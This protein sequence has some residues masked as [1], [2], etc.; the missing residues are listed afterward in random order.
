MVMAFGGPDSLSAVGPFMERLMKGRKPGP[1][2][3]ERVKDKYQIIGGKSPL[4]GITKKQA[5][6]LEEE[7]NRTC[8]EHGQFAAY[9]GMRYWH[10]FIEEAIEQMATDGITRAFAISMSPHDS[11]VS[12]GAY[13]EE[14]ERV[15]A[16]KN[17]NISIEM[18][19]GMYNN[20][21]FVDAVVEKITEAL[22]RIPEDARDDVQ[23][24]FSAHSLP[25]AY[26]DGGDPYVD[27]IN[28]TIRE[29]L[30]KTGSPNW[31]IAYQSK[32]SI[33]GEWLGPMMEDVLAEIAAE[34]HKRVLVVPIG[35]AADHVETLWD[36]DILHKGQAED[37]G[38]LY[39]RSGALNDSPRFMEALAQMV[40]TALRN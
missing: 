18:I 28:E 1:E 27:E 10:P 30:R 19:R 35:F 33:P 24:I 17:L 9:V 4:P 21:I 7:L 31:R 3:I 29:V 2:L 38:L 32:G 34:G 37:L 16:E 13:R 14:I 40:C 15:L 23:V 8:V 11:R 26:I 39:E 12:T 22:N 6:A 36:L 25:V 5:I 20:P